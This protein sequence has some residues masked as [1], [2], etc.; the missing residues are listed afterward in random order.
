[1]LPP[2]DYTNNM[3]GIQVTVHFSSAPSETKNWTGV[4][5]A[6]PG[7][8]VSGDDG[9]WGLRNL[10]PPL[11]HTFSS[12]WELSYNAGGGV[13]GNLIAFEIDGFGKLLSGG[14]IVGNTAFDTTNPS[15]GTVGSAQ[16]RDFNVIGNTHDTDATYIDAIKLSAAAVPVGDLYRRLRVEFKGQVETK[17]QQLPLSSLGENIHS[18][19]DWR[20][21]TTPNGDRQ[22]AADDF[23]SDGRPITG[24]RWWGSYF[25]SQDQPQPDPMNQNLVPPVE[26]GYVVSFFQSVA[27]VAG[28]GPLLGTYVAPASVVDIRPTGMVGWDGHPVWE[29]AVD[30]DQTLLEH[31]SDLAT[32]ESFNEQEDTEYWIS[33]AA[34][35]GHAINVDT[36]ETID[37]GDPIRTAPW[38]GW[39]STPE[40]VTLPAFAD[41]A[42]YA[43]NVSMDGDQW[44]Y[45]PWN[46]APQQHPSPNLNNLAFELLTVDGGTIGLDGVTD[47]MMSFYADTDTVVAVPEPS[48]LVLIAGA[49]LLALGR[50]GGR[51][52]RS[53]R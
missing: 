44:V 29:Y 20:L 13:K 50:I 30:L 35:D 22:A 21:A 28:P 7:G 26:E 18:D 9:D 48:S 10:T 42:P 23:I 4:G 46:V 51:S 25:N 19:I 6:D 5:F 16:G 53:R 41:E 34:E 27:G 2:F 49:A 8:G 38:W 17:W 37:T 52:A 15:T 40:A 3:E 32:R 36:G 24:V 43:A 12:P 47:T 33:I 1:V 11:N 45:A 31:A 14:G 39:H